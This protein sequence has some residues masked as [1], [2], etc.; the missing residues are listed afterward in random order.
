MHVSKSGS[1]AVGAQ[2]ERDVRWA[3]IDTNHGTRIKGR[4]RRIGERLNT[5]PTYR[6]VL[7]VHLYIANVARAPSQGTH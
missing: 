2:W 6:P 4:V 5:P 7:F 3:A 1:N